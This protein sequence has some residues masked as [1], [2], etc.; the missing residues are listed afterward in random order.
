VSKIARVKFIRDKEPNIKALT[1]KN[2][3]LDG[4]LY[5]A[6]DTGTLWMG[7]SSSSL[8]QI[9]DNINTNTTYNLTKSGNTITLSGSDGSTF[10]V[11]DSNTVYGN[12]TAS[13]AGL[14]SAADKAKLD[15]VSAGSNYVAVDA[16]LST[17]ST[18][19][20]QNKVIKSALDGKSNTGHT[21]DD[22]YYTESEIN[23]KLNAKAN[24]S[25]THTK[26][27]ITDFPT[28]MPA[29]DVYAWA[30]AAS[31]PSYTISEVSGNLPASR[32]SGVIDAAQLPSYV[33]DV[34]EGYLNGGQ[35]YTTKSSSGAYSGEI[36]AEAGKIYV[37]LSNNKTYRWSGSTYV[38]I[39]ETIALGTTHST[40]GYGDESRAA[41]NHST[42]TGNPHKTT[43]A[44]LG[45]DS[46]ENKS[47]ATIRGELTSANV[48]T[49]LG[50]T[51]PKTD[52]NT[53]YT[54]HI[55]AGAK[56]GTANAATTNG[57]THINVTDDNT[58]R[59]GVV[60]KGTGATSVT[61]D[62][63][64]N[65][66]VYSTDTD[67]WRPVQNNLTSTATDQSLSAAQGKALNDKFSS[68]VPASRTVNGKALSANITLS[69]G[70]V[71]AA[72]ASHSHPY[73]PLAGGTMDGSIIRRTSSSW[74][75][76]RNNTI[77][78]GTGTIHGSYNPVV[79][80]KT[81]EGAWTIGNLGGDER[82]IFNYGTDTN[83]NDH[84]NSTSQTYL[85][86]GD[87][88][89]EI[90]TSATIGL[91]SVNHAKTAGSVAWSDIS[92]KPSTYV[93][94]SHTH[95]DRYY[96]ASEINTKLNAKAN[97]SH[98]H[99]K[100]QITDFPTSM[101]A[102]DVYAWA[103]AASKPS[104]TISEVSGNLPASRISGVIDA[105]QLPSYVDDVI[106]GYLN[107]GQFYTTKSSSGA[108]S[109]EIKAE[110]GK[111]Y[112]DLSNNKTYRWSGSTYVVISETIA[113]G[114]THSTAGYG[115]ESRAAYNHST[116]TGNPHKTTKADLGLDSVE[117]KSSATIRGE[118]TSANVT[119]A[120][121]YTPPKTD[122][123]T[124]YTTHIVAGAKSG[125]ANAATTNGNT[126]INVT[127]DNTFRS[128]VVIKGTGATS[129]TSDASGNITVY[130]TD[131]DTWRPVQNNLTSTATDQSLSAAQGKA[132]NDKFSSYV[133][134]SRT[135]NGKALSA[136]ITL[137]AGDVGAAPASHSHPYLP[138]AGGT[139][140]GS[141]IRR[142]SSSWIDDRNNTIVFGTGT[143]HGSYN[144]VVGQKTTEGAW[145][146]G[147]L[148]GD[149]RLIFN[150]G[151]DTNFN[152]HNNST[153]Q[154]YLPTG[155]GSQ[156]IITSAT[157]G[158][159]SV[160]HAKTAGSVAW[161]DISNKPSTYVPSSHT[162]DDRYY[163]AS[164]MNT[165][166]DAK[167]A[168]DIITISGTKP[169]SDTCKL[170]I[171]I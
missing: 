23:T 144:P 163:T 120:L 137:S 65:I 165:R 87:G 72:P 134:A 43:K 110:A 94:S 171:Q 84:N 27:Q 103:K 85:P 149:E 93:P 119:T 130:S 50:Y 3:V 109:G 73:L 69:A 161:S 92:N 80:Q 160:N 148:G 13:A 168:S 104:Y 88:S 100:A 152:D 77:V 82:L 30:K 128:G 7:I 31:K 170:W 75:D 20:V 143:I 1:A 89:Q 28:S 74:I 147:N 56:S 60:I 155:D 68:Y 59:S 15:G 135:V 58:F 71:G 8:I 22:R 76:D 40:A 129:V 91:Q 107:G 38:V 10:N 118:L 122:T 127:D 66:T 34:I 141:I 138:L 90:I 102:S 52:T 67:T 154:T 136:N 36:K 21:H 151:T 54:T 166:L 83:F 133:P 126:H 78:F 33:D 162:H 169:T 113:L 81:T 14:M 61:S 117:N 79:G 99:T 150:Y 9:K 17:T 123:N 140:D 11:T 26:A 44:D 96:T 2:E 157:I 70:D 159:Q 41:Y 63:S 131:T 29:S 111:I 6:T 116:S 37:D 42:S 121:G 39:S 146:I 108:Y 4:A 49:A 124:H 156:E 32:I 164:E 18:N 114:T 98:T 55:V 53:H 46:V 97:S 25:H 112:V 101:P 95:D 62:A 142:T 115:D 167:A 139:M 45:L 125:T 64:G 16:E 51:P 57:N 24:S 106:E 48:T 35:F 105:A 5:V 19:P 12:A 158:L 145:T 132:L 86:T 47:S 153:S